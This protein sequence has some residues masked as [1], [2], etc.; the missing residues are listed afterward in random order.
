MG[1][2]AQWVVD[3]APAESGTKVHIEQT[4]LIRLGS[5]HAPMFRFIM[6]LGGGAKMGPKDLIRRLMAAHG[7]AA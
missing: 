2:T 1:M 3:L 4:G 7:G 6:R 5:F